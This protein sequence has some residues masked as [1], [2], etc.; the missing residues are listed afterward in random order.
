MNAIVRQE[1]I[2]HELIASALADL[3]TG[4]SLNQVAKDRGIPYATLRVW[5]LDDLGDEYAPL[6]RRALLCRIAEADEAIENA[7]DHI[8]I[9]RAREMGKFSRFDAERRIRSWSPR[10]ELTGA[11]GGPIQVEEPETLRRLAFLM[12]KE[13]E[14]LDVSAESSQVTD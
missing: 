10:Q 7:Q 12:K 5:M 13:A 4:K 6:Q 14:T 11:N 2:R 3:E 9:A 1:P 8:A